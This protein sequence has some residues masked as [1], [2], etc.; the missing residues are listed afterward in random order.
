MSAHDFVRRLCDRLFLTKTGSRVF[1]CCSIASDHDYFGAYSEFAD[2]ELKDAGFSIKGKGSNIILFD[3]VRYIGVS[4]TGKYDIFL[5]KEPIEQNIYMTAHLWAMSEKVRELASSKNDF[6]Q[7]FN[8][9]CRLIAKEKRYEFKQK[10]PNDN[11]SD[12]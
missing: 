1:G 9:E 10:R 3:T 2:K 6:I 12:I 5:F 7:M 8:A 11:D 4:S